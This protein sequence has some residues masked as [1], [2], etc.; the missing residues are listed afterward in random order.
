MKIVP[1]TSELSAAF[2]GK[3]LPRSS[4]GYFLLNESGEP[5]ATA[6]FV[7]R[8]RDEM[9]LYTEGK[10][11]IFQHKKEIIKFARFILDIADSKG[12]TLYSQADESLMTAH[13]FATH[14]GFERLEN[15]EYIRWAR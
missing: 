7:R 8:F 9:I 14:F 15:G 2:Y 3:L 13:G 4:R 12:W 5:I 11:E 1:A 6:G 10:P